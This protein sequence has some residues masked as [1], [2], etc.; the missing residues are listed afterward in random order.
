MRRGRR[1]RPDDLSE[2]QSGRSP[3]V[4]DHAA[5]LVP[6]QPGREIVELV[7]LR[8]NGR[9]THDPPRRRVGAAEQPLDLHFVADLA[10]LQADHVPLVEDEKADIVEKGWFV[11]KGEVELLRRR[12]D[13]IALPDGVLV[14]AANADAALKSRYRLAKRTEGALQGRFR[15]RRQSAQRGDE[16]HPLAA[17]ETAQDAELRYPG[18]AGAG[19]QRNDQIVGLIHGTRRRVDL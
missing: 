2:P 1:F 7:A 12:H 14:E 10:L 15:L 11:A 18:L 6:P 13:Y 8:Q 17:G 5:R 16:D 19:W 4:L 9:Q 3:I